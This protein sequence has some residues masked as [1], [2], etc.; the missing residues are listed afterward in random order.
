MIGAT[1]TP[2]SPNTTTHIRP[3]LWPPP[4]ATF[5]LPERYSSC[6]SIDED[7]K[8][9]IREITACGN[10]PHRLPSVTPPH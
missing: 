10:P 3:P 6:R 4:A 2:A 8:D 9:A 5:V 7:E 1:G